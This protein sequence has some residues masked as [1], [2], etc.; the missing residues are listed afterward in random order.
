[1]TGHAEQEQTSFWHG[2]EIITA[3]LLMNR[4]DEMR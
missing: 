1:M 2:P 3:E 4:H